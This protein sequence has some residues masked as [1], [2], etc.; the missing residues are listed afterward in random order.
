VSIR[1]GICRHITGK[2]GNSTSKGK[3]FVGF[4]VSVEKTEWIFRSDY[5]KIQL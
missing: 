4:R 5:V 2:S 3:E 1:G